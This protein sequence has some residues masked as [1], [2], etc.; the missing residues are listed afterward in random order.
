MFDNQVLVLVFYEQS[1]LITTDRVLCISVQKNSVI[2]PTVKIGI[3]VQNGH[4]IEYFIVYFAVRD[5][6]KE[7]G[8]SRETS[9]RC[10]VDTRICNGK[11]NRSLWMLIAHCRTI[12]RHASAQSVW[13]RRLSPSSFPSFP[14]ERGNR[15]N[16]IS[17]AVCIKAI[18]NATCELLRRTCIFLNYRNLTILTL[19]YIYICLVSL[20]SV[21][22]DR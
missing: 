12:S 6:G 8:K 13:D 4:D 7:S 18:W 19:D 20:V 21:T 3:L 9:S 17:K 15:R 5:I 16:A 22:F 1:C 14:R 2:Y 11:A 10:L